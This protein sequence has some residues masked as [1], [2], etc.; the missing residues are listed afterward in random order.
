[1]RNLI[2]RLFLIIVTAIIFFVVR[3]FA[4]S[5]FVI[6]F[7]LL[8]GLVLNYK[9]TKNTFDTISNYFFWIIMFS[10]INIFKKIS[11]ATLLD[12]F[13]VLLVFKASV[14]VYNYFKYKKVAVPNSHLSKIWIFMFCLYQAEIILNSTHGLKNICFL[15]GVISAIETFL[16]IFRNKE[17]KFNVVSFW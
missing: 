9:T 7:L 16:I 15:L 3:E 17:W 6:A 12:S 4:Y 2:F 1:M 11:F 5:D 13:V 14:L 10:L 8:I